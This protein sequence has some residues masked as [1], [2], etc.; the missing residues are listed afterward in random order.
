MSCFFWE[1]T[2]LSK[3]CFC[4]LHFRWQASIILSYIL[5][6]ELAQL[7]GAPFFKTNGWAHPSPYPVLPF[8]DGWT[9]SDWSS[10]HLQDWQ[11]WNLFYV[12]EVVCNVRASSGCLF[13]VDELS[14]FS[15]SNEPHRLQPCLIPTSSIPDKVLGTRSC[16]S[17]HHLK[18]VIL[19]TFIN[20]WWNSFTR[21]YK[22][23]R[24]SC[25]YK[26]I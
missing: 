14:L 22:A 4:K 2:L 16:L 10:S 15:P 19:Y 18:T 23:I 12:H 6:M 25:I 5:M 9:S 26:G 7:M 20:K 8:K 11:S 17:P 1:C 24:L 21:F 3:T 13:G